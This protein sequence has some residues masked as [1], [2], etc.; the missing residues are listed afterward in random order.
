MFTN[1]ISGFFEQMEQSKRMANSASFVTVPGQLIGRSQPFASSQDIYRY[2][3]EC[4]KAELH[5]RLVALL[6]SRWDL[7][8]L[9]RN[10]QSS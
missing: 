5:N 9:T 7:T 6:R 4:A 8:H 2:A 10:D 3:Y 1:R